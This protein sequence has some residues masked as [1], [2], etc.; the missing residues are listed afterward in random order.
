MILKQT[1]CSGRFWCW[2]LYC[3]KI[4]KWYLFNLHTKVFHVSHDWN[5]LQVAK[6]VFDVSKEKV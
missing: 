5:H 4:D 1:V 2:L 3:Y 6:F